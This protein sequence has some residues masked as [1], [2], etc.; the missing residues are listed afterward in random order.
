MY[1]DFQNAEEISKFPAE[2]CAFECYL[3]VRLF[4]K[5]FTFS[6]ILIE[7]KTTQLSFT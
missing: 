4:R 2:G 6:A 5:P 1:R 7:T 3:F